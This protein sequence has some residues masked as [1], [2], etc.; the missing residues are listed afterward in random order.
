MRIRHNRIHLAMI[1]CR[2]LLLLCALLAFAGCVSTG[3]QP[4]TDKFLVSVPKAQFYKYGPAQAFG[5]DFN[6]EKGQRVTM[7]KR[8]F[9]Y[10][11]I[12]LADGQTGYVA[13]DEIAP[14]PPPPPPPRSTPRPRSGRGDGGR[15]R[16]SNV[17]PVTE[18]P[19]FDIT[20]IPLP[21]PEDPS[22]APAAPTP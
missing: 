14:A 17:Q 10:S 1:C 11:Q 18:D 19:L 12:Q 22:T 9:G 8:E 16:R 3:P 2:T 6:L 15:P 20:D 13:T 4:P 7:L 5:A 21:M